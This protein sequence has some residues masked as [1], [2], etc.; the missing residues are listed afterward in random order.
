MLRCETQSNVPFLCFNEKY[1]LF[2]LTALGTCEELKVKSCANA[3][4]KFTAQYLPVEG[5]PFQEIKGEILDAYL[6][7]LQDCSP[8]SSLILC[9]L[10]LPKCV[11]GSGKPMLPCRQVCFDFAE[12]CKDYLRLSSTAGMVVAFCDLLPV[13]DGTPDKCILPDNFKLSSIAC[14]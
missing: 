12:K 2:L 1:F 7:H 5:I 8:F 11:K 9:S 14:E 6:P 3:G 10:F 13:Y 4:Y